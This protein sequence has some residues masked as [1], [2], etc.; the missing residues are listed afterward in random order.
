MH[1]IIIN[2]F[3]QFMYGVLSCVEVLVKTESGPV[4]KWDIR[5][6]LAARKYISV[7]QL[8]K[9]TWRRCSFQYSLPGV[10]AVT[11]QYDMIPRWHTYNRSQVADHVPGSLEYPKAAVPKII[12]RICKRT[13]W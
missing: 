4:W 11:C 13:P 10:T 2:R 8:V 6:L 1:A 3:S 12:H 9:K 7:Y 5:N